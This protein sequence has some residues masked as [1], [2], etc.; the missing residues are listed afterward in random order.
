MGGDGICDVN[1]MLV[2]EGYG[3]VVTSPV[4]AAFVGARKHTNNTA[5]LSALA[6]LFRSLLHT[7]PRPA[8]S[9]G[10]GHSGHKWN[11][12]VDKQADLGRSGA[13]YCGAPEWQDE[14]IPTDADD[15]ESSTVGDDVARHIG[16][17][18]GIR[19]ERAIDIDVL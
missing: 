16:D 2:T 17:N 15:G 13:R 7:A 6:E 3:P 8:G 11:D 10:V 18:K 14:S 1:A 4:H 9:R 5:E 19:R 12:Y